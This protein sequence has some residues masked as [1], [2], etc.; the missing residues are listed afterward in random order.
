MWP[1]ARSRPADSDVV[2]AIGKL[3][4]DACE[5]AQRINMLEARLDVIEKTIILANSTRQGR[6]T[7]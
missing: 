4:D 5:K 2:Y 1:F 6:G 7:P 3:L